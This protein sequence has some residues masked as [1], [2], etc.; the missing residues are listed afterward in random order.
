[1]LF[2][3]TLA[4]SAAFAL[5]YLYSFLLAPLMI[6]QLGLDAFGV[7]AV[8]GAFATYAGLLDLGVGRSLAR[9]VAV[10]NAAGDERKIR[11]CL[12]LGVL[13][14]TVVGVLALAA[15]ALLA[16]LLSN[17]LGVLD[18]G[19]MRIVLLSAVA[20]W[21]FNG[22]DGVLNAVGIGKQKMV[23]PNVAASVTVSINFS[24]SVVALLA[25]GALPVYAGAN[26]AAALLG[27]IP[28]AVAMRHVWRGPY[29]AI[30]SRVLMREVIGF[31]LKNQLA[32]FAELINLQTD[33]VIIAL[34]VDVR[35]AAVYEIGSRVVIAV[36]S[37]AAMSVSAI[38]PTAAAR[39]VEEGRG[40]IGQ[41]YRRYTA[42][43]CATAFPLFI[44]ASVSAP[45]LLVA[46]L[47]DVPGD[48]GLVVP[49]LSAAY[50]VNITTGAATTL[51]VGAGQPGLAAVN[52]VQIAILNVLLTVALA[53]LF[54]LWGVVAGTAVA[55]IIGST[56]FNVRFLRLFEL[57]ERTFWESVRPPLG[58][59][60]GLAIPAAALALLVG[61]PEDRALAVALLAASMLSYLPPYWLLAS[62]RGLLPEKL[63]YPLRRPAAASPAS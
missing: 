20:I 2:R 42:L 5:G 10:F 55:L 52:S 11:E 41:M 36:R 57:P 56:V 21:T 26:A 43:S 46:W 39:I 50:L 47:G 17:D 60:F 54:G 48:A 25:S 31:S 37:A 51:A 63:S 16:P 18:E 30:P 9:F 33:K 23:P 6:A 1:M 3:N 15:A 32:W 27:I 29:F 61:L 44:A 19:E 12:G 24:F 40:V 35:A 38:I 58:L 7:W 59:A 45:F 62:R 28:A 14:V 49:I 13:I 4:Q 34:M 8:T 53:P 22:F